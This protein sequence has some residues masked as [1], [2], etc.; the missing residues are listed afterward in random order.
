MTMKMVFWTLVETKE[1]NALIENYKEKINLYYEKY[2]KDNEE[3]KAKITD[4]NLYNLVLYEALNLSLSK[5]DTSD[6]DSNLNIIVEG[7]KDK[8]TFKHGDFYKFGLFLTTSQKGRPYINYLFIK[9]LLKIE[10]EA[11]LEKEYKE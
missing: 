1:I 9:I 8:L 7:I 6:F 2:I 11:K 4:T 10:T 3:N 5:A